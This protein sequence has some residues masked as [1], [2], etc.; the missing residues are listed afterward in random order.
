MMQCFDHQKLDV[1]KVA[2]QW[3][4]L[5]EKIA[6]QL[7]RGRAYFVDQLQRAATSIPL[8]IAEGAGKYLV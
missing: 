8:N 7:P 2:I 4:I 1:Y 6:L 3:I 5:S